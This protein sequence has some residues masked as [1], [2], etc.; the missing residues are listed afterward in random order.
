MRKS[1]RQFRS[2]VPR[3]PRRVPILLRTRTRKGGVAT[4]AAGSSRRGRIYGES[5]TPP[6]TAGGPVRGVSLYPTSNPG[7]SL[8]PASAPTVTLRPASDPGVSITT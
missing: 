5:S 8:Y 3:Q 7:V 6:A 4:M 2:E 1:R